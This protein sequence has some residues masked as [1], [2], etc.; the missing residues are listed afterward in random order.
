MPGRLNYKDPDD[1]SEL[2]RAPRQ[3]Q[4]RQSSRRD[5]LTRKAQSGSVSS[6]KP[7][8][9]RLTPV[10]VADAAM[11]HDAVLKILGEVG[12]IVDHDPSRRMLIEQAGCREGADGYLRMP[13]DL[14]ERAIATIP[15]KITLY[16]LNGRLRVDT[17][18]K[19]SSYC[20][21][22][23]CVRVLDH[24]TRELRP[25]RLEDVKNTAILCEKL[26]NIDMACSLGY[27]SDVPAEDEAVETVRAMVENSSK[28]AAILAHD[29][30]I[31]ETCCIR[32]RFSGADSRRNPSVAGTGRRGSVGTGRQALRQMVRG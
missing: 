27:P 24:R 3:A 18:S 21:G 1:M 7:Q 25:C 15:D 6:R 16:D 2:S 28:P 29:D 5:K 11:I 13:P 20:P 19:V 17:S 10:G 23:N 8:A 31:Q 30:I 4:R 22:H 14:V 32:F 26:P 9:L 12:V